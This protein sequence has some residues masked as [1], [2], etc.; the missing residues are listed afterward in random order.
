M[1]FFLVRKGLS[2][3]L[4][5]GQITKILSNSKKFQVEVTD[6]NG[7]KAHGILFDQH[8]VVDEIKKLKNIRSRGSVWDISPQFVKSN[9]FKFTT[10][11]KMPCNL[12]PGGEVYNLQI[13]RKT[14]YLGLAKCVYNDFL[15]AKLTAEEGF[16]SNNCV[17]RIV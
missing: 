9:K 17:I 6:C 12:V 1:C 7:K 14:G 5:F 10:G 4:T 11:S 16:K 8:F 2:S 13:L 15:I 3:V